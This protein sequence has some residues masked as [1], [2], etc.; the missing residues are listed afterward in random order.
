MITFEEIKKYAEEHYEAAI[1]LLLELAPI[2]APSHNEELRAEFCKKWLDSI[3][4]EGVYIDEALNVV[5]PYGDTEGELKVFMAHS[6]VVFPD[7]APLPLERRDK[8]IFCPGVGDD[9][10]HAVTLL[11]AAKY[12]AENKPECKEGGILIVINSCEE[13]LGN[14]KGCRHIMER[15]G[16]RVTE[17]VTFDSHPRSVVTRAVG[18]HRYNIEI[19]TEGGHSYGN[20][21]RTN[22]IAVMAQLINKLYSVKLPE[23]GRTTYNVGTVSGGTSVNTIAQNAEMLY[24]YRSDNADNLAYMQEYFLDIIKSFEST[25]A[26]INVTKVGDRPCGSNVDEARQNSLT[27]KAIKTIE[28]AYGYTPKL[29]TGS[30]DCNVPL[31]MGIPSVCVGCVRS[32]GAHTRGEYVLEESLEN[33]ITVALSMISYALK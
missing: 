23:S 5:Y 10:A 33:G 26:E 13:G 32:S 14:L 27:D 3:G 9:T 12:L 30:T 11:M 24:E 7:T 1:K 21:G 19:K 15:F 6:D 17:F 31:S 8:K 16:G 22:A 28:N 18:S 29:G 4:A 20:F 2:P 25:D